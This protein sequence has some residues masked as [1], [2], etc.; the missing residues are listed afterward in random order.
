MF[1]SFSQKF[2]IKRFKIVT[3]LILILACLFLIVNVVDKAFSRYESR[4][5]VSAEA[6]VA[7]FVV[8]QGTYE[9]TISL[10]G[11]TPSATPFYYTFYVANYNQNGKRSNVDMEYT[12]KFET[13]TNLPLSY[14]IVRNETFTSGYTN[15][16]EDSSVRQDE[17]DVFYKVFTNNQK[18]SFSHKRDEADS[19]TL[20]VV[21]PESYKNS[22]DLYQ[23]VIELFSI[24]IDA[25]QVA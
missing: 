13:T 18:Y 5:D 1:Q 15:I 10:T 17:Y 7:F 20:K 2:D 24:I 6:N 19:Y 12:I 23:G 9:N 21:F 14:E 22:P 8:D 3:Q 16:I 25:T 4:V 11:L